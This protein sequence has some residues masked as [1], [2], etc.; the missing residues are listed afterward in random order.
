MTTQTDQTIAPSLDSLDTNDR[1][2]LRQLAWTLIR[3]AESDH[4][5]EQ[6]ARSAANSSLATAYLALANTIPTT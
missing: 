2:N 6:Y 1:D 5:R 4:R 3:D